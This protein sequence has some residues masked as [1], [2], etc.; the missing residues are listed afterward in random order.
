MHTADLTY[1]KV[2]IVDDDLTVGLLAREALT[3]GGFDVSLAH[4]AAQMQEEFLR[5]QPDIILLDVQ[6]PDCNGIMLCTEL[7]GTPRHAQTP[8][9]MITGSDDHD[10]I[11]A[12]Y[13]AGATDFMPK[14]LNWYLLVQRVRYMWRSHLILLNSQENERLLAQAQLMAM[15]GNW[16]KKLD[17]G[18][19]TTSEQFI[20]LFGNTDWS[21]TDGFL[22]FLNTIP[23]AEQSLV[24]QI[25]E[26]VST[27][28]Q[29]RTFDHHV[30][31]QDGTLRNVRHTLEVRKDVDDTPIA[32]CGTVQ[33]IT[34][35]KLRAQLAA[36]RNHI[37]E[38]VL[39]NADVTALYKGLDTLL[40]NQFP[41]SELGVLNRTDAGWQ[42]VHCARTL[43][44]LHGHG[45]VHLPPVI[46][47]EIEDAATNRKSLQYDLNSFPEFGQRHSRLSVLPVLVGRET[48]PSTLLCIFF[49]RDT[50]AH[51]PSH[52]EE[53]VQTI[54]GISAITLEN[55]R[56]SNDLR[57]QAFHDSL[58]GLPNRFLFLDRLA[59]AVSEGT[60][61]GEKRAVVFIDLDRFKNTNDLLGHNFGDKVLREVAR[62][63]RN[64]TRQSD[65]LAR[66]GGDEFMLISAPLEEYAQ[67]DT[68]C[69]RIMDIMTVPFEEDNYRINLSVSIGVSFFPIDGEDPATL[70]QHADVAMHHA[71]KCGGN[72]IKFYDSS[73]MDQFLERLELENAMLRA[74]DQNE[75]FLVFQPQ[76]ETANGIT[77]GYEALIRWRK[78]D[79]RFIPPAT[80]IPIAEETGFI[81]TLGAWV[82]EQACLQIKHLHEA[83]YPDI[84]L[85]VNVSTVQF[86]QDNFLDQ[87]R[88]VLDKTGFPANR[89]EL[90]VTESAV[91][92]DITTVAARLNALRALGIS[93]AIDDFGT[94]YS[95]M[96]YLKS[97]PIDG[98]KIDRS[99]I[100]EI[101]AIH[102]GHIKSEAL[103]DALINLAENL[104]LLVVAEG[105]E[106]EEQLEFLKRKNCHYVQ[107][108]FTGR[109]APLPETIKK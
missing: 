87:V 78:E 41:G 90:E 91:M 74:M 100:T 65:T 14:P 15:V 68:V 84:K 40:S 99:F 25:M 94:G 83:G 35:D 75:F 10:S 103:V 63:L 22:P 31:R 26:Q 71:K 92:H 27:T 54:T 17:T 56:L 46:L 48:T 67:I 53:V 85:A 86:V 93:I 7:R 81:V 11:L 72:I 62:R 102:I 80:F 98:L 104:G 21:L 55:Y 76:I 9:L 23:L 4:S 61:S 69:S 24:A 39:Q 18:R 58:T 43:E 101:D 66:M 38:L 8:I 49:Q 44:A 88:T 95:S 108:Y 19:V 107:G 12:A 37:L 60:R 42:C 82:L 13:G 33:D 64:V 57:F 45:T 52:Y 77:A 59:Q 36:D 106:T 34:R 28:G 109:P 2:L 5:S 50:L 51:E 6:L 47:H 1:P 32:L 30:Q 105:V 20:K 70:H 29:G 97:L 79:G 3:Q 96:A 73:I 89:L 16:E